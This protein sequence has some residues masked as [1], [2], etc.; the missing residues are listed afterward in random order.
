MNIAIIGA[1]LSGLALCWHLLQKQGCKVT[2]FDA[3]GIGGGASGVASGLLHPYTGQQANRSLYATEAMAATLELLKV[4]E[5][6]LQRPVADY[7][8]I[9][10]FAIHEK[11]K[12]AL[13]KRCQEYDD[14]VQLEDQ[15]FLIRSGITVYTSLYM[16]GLWNAC[17]TLGAV[18]HIAKI[19]DLNELGHYDQ[20]FI[21]AGV[22]TLGFKECQE[23]P[24]KCNKGQL[25]T[26]QLEKPL[27]R[28]LIGNGY[29]ALG[30]TAGTCYV[31]ATYERGYTHDLPD[32][33]QALK[34]L[35]GHFPEFCT[36]ILDCRAGIRVVNRTH[37]LPIAQKLSEKL[38]ILT[39]MGSRGLLYHAHFT[40]L[41]L[42]LC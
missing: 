25:L 31:G 35:E 38:Y 42:M 4:A 5:T 7:N 6:T 17:Q 39:G 8:G 16:Q 18:L 34:G 32:L 20:V 9:V 2:L 28:S 29:V 40:K 24:V 37:Y 14:I 41:I 27:E 15:S 23:L 36:T 3:K 26:C 11:Q 10:R 13:L 21:A 30:H 22:G 12:E 19:N 33:P 1:G